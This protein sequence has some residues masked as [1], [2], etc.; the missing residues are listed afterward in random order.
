MKNLLYIGNKLQQTNKTLTTI[1]TLSKNLQRESYHVISASGKKNKLFRLFDMLYHIV[2]HRKTT[3][4]VLIDTYS[5]LNFYYAYLCSKLCVFFKLKYIPMLHGG[6]LPE[7]LKSSPKLSASIF[8]KAHVNIAPSLYI[9]SSFEDSGFENVECIPNAIEIEN[10]PFKKRHFDK[11]KL[12]WVRSFSKIYNPTLAIKIA[13]IL[14]DKHMDVALCMVGPDND[15]SLDEVKT[16][17]K[18]LNIT[19]RFTGKL[20]K[21][22]WIKLSEDYNIFINTTNFDNMPVSVIEAMALGL[23]VVSTNVGGMSFLI[24]DGVDGILVR[25]NDE[26]AFVEAVNKVI[27]SIEDIEKMT[28]LARKKVENFDWEIVK[29]QWI[30]VLK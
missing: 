14:K 22:A 2:K 30:S 6:N 20:P 8:N 24:E 5:T 3:D 27:S 17:A 16:L 26:R 25:P 23:P 9:K 13:K 1:D 19:V 28:L 11:V 15:G 29:H 10:Y 4:Y 7:R 21:E 12:L 18:K